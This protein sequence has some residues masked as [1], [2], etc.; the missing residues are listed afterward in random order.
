[1]K[2]LKIVIPCLLLSACA[3]GRSKDA[4]YYTNLPISASGMSFDY[5]SSVGVN[6]VQLPKYIDR[7]QIVT[8]QKDSSQ[9]KISEFNR[10]VESPSQLTTRALTNNLSILL[11]ASQVKHTRSNGD[12]FDRFVS[13]EVVRMTAILGDHVELIAWYTIKDDAKKTLVEQKFASTTQIGKTYDDLAQGYNQLLAELSQAIAE[14]L[15]SN[16]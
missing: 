13:V 11:P 1:M 12:K 9:V 8:Q 5:N 10:W 2:L 6:R 3:L 14:N 16:K 7:P 15:V 4:K